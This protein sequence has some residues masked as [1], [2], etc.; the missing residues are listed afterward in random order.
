MRV[1]MDDFGPTLLGFYHIS[2]RHGMGLGHVA[3]HDQNSIAI[4]EVLRKCRGTATPQ[5]C[6]Q[7]GYSRAVSYTCLV[8]NRD[9]AKTTAEEL[10]H[11]IIF[12]NVQCCPTERS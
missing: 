3:T 9:D 8:L 4:D 2:K 7:T 1:Y 10:F 11:Q 12:F 6:T 5:R